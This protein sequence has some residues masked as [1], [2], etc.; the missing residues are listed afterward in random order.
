MPG[1]FDPFHEEIHNH[2]TVIDDCNRKAGN[3]NRINHNFVQ[4]TRLVDDLAETDDLEARFQTDSISLEPS[5][6]AKLYSLGVCLLITV[7]VSDTADRG[8]DT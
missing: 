2:N 4:Q 5:H 6:L 3:S 7:R 8:V 1:I